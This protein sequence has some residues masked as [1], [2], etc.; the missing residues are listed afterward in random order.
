MSRQCPEQLL[1][2]TVHFQRQLLREENVFYLQSPGSLIY[3]FSGCSGLKAKMVHGENV[4][5]AD[6]IWLYELM[7]LHTARRSA[8]TLC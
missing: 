8:Q 4:W 2:Q 7:C 5:N 6:F 1:I 3:P